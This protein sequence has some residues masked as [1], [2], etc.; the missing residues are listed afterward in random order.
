MVGLLVSALA[1]NLGEA[2]LFSP[3]GFG[4][5]V[6]LAIGMAVAP[7]VQVNTQSNARRTP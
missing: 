4:L 2:V 7:S 3:S 6:W 5:L 1:I